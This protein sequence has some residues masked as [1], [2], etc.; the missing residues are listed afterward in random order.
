M[1]SLLKINK[2]L[3]QIGSQLFLIVL[4]TS[5][6][7]AD[8]GLMLNSFKK[9]ENALKYITTQAKSP[10]KWGCN[11]FLEEVQVPDKGRW[12]RVCLGPFVDKKEALKYK[13]TLHS[14][15]FGGDVVLV[16]TASQAQAASLLPPTPPP[17][18]AL[19]SSEVESSETESVY[20]EK[21]LIPDILGREV[22]E[23]APHDPSGETDTA[24]KVLDYEGGPVTDK[25]EPE[26]E[27]PWAEPADAFAITL[28]KATLLA[29]ENNWAFRVERFSPDIQR[30][31]EESERA[32][33]DPIL[34]AEGGWQR[35]RDKIDSVTTGPV[36]STGISEFLPT[37][38]WL[39]LDFGVEQED[40]IIVSNPD[41][42]YETNLSLTVTQAL[43][44]G[45]GLDVNL[46]SLRQARIDTRASEYQL[47]GLAQSLLA[48]VENSYWDYTL[49][50]EEVKIYEASVKLG[51][52]LTKETIE[53]I[54]LGQLAK[55]E[56]F[57]GESETA[58]RRQDLIDAQ[59]VR[60]N[61]R[62][63]LLRLLNPPGDNFWQ[64]EV[65]LLTP[66][67]RL[68]PQLE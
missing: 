62:L 53:R 4:V 9:R 33:F 16:K 7:H 27:G 23:F 3:K 68:D 47:R 37:G 56:I 29:L 52:E 14:K 41:E 30:T 32:A 36:V 6:A 38:T 1:N 48:E 65:V 22:T 25:E 13:E 19:K 12:Y 66:P 64:R 28:E 55:S 34:R 39:D 10:L 24:D 17:K 5:M 49:A 44:R 26:K 31:Y 2:G 35:D 58:Q 15:G 67:E 50:K 45:R 54:E 46:A 63:R 40:K 20:S 57:Y 51:E 60:A 59:S 8:F 11:V 18:P 61:A 43:L 21:K 42:E